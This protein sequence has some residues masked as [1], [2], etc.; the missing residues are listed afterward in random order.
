M[1]L[2][3]HEIVG[4]RGDADGDKQV[5]KKAERKAEQKFVMEVEFFGYGYQG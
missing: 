4:R 5:I 3:M 1:G 2:S